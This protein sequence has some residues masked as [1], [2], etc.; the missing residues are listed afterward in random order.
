VDIDHGLLSVQNR[1][2]R[3]LTSERKV[4]ALFDQIFSPSDPLYE[5][6]VI[7]IRRNARRLT[8]ASAVLVAISVVQAST[9][10]VVQFM[11]MLDDVG[12]HKIS[13]E[14]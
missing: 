14:C 7:L 10:S 2:F 6:S 1:T 11:Y 9:I 12:K 4:V 13:A 5:V 3:N 8:A